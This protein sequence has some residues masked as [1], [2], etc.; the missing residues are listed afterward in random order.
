THLTA[1]RMALAWLSVTLLPI[2]PYLIYSS[3][4]TVPLQVRML[5]GTLVL[6]LLFASTLGWAS[7]W[8]ANKRWLNYGFVAVTVPT[9]FLIVISMS[10]AFER[11][12]GFSSLGIFNRISTFLLVPRFER[13][14]TYRFD[15]MSRFIN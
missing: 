5:T 8:E 15:E 9:V 3:L 6:P 13:V 4:Y 10:S 2:V 1:A 11:L 12:Q 14:T 7:L